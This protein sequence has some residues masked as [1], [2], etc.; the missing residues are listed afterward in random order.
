ML[1]RSVSWFVGAEAGGC[2]QK[3]RANKKKTVPIASQTAKRMKVK[4][5]SSEFSYREHEAW[6]WLCFRRQAWSNIDP[7][8]IG[9]GMVPSVRTM[10]HWIPRAKDFCRSGTL[11]R[12]AVRAGMVNIIRRKVEMVKRVMKISM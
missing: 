4:R 10:I 12:V 3:N 7:K 1:C 11:L 6:S 2:L 8:T 9:P 5:L